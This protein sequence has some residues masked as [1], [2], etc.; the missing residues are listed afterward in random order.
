[1]YGA[2]LCQ[3]NFSDLE[4]IQQL[5]QQTGLQA[6]QHV[7]DLGCGQ[8][9][10]AEY[11]SDQTGAHVSGIDS[12]PAAIELAQAR[13]A[14]KRERLD[15]RVGNMDCLDLAPAQ[16]DLVYAV[17]SLCMACD[18]PASLA[19]LRAA[20]KPGGRLAAFDFEIQFGEDACLE[21]LQPENTLLARAFDQLGWPWQ[22]VDFSKQT[23]QM[24]QRKCVLAEA[25]KSRF[26]AEGNAFLYEH[27]AMELESCPEPYL[28]EQARMRRYLYM[29]NE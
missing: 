3:T 17:D 16:F 28:P 10:L 22:A 11:L 27:L 29:T 18:L 5:V 15:F 19:Q 21:D 12:A 4:Q 2:N 13:T 24:M 8:G 9:L 20:L 23:Y 7:L 14:A 1:M 26:E 25:F 6:G